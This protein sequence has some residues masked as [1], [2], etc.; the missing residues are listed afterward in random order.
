MITT[1]NWLC[2]WG[3]LLLLGACEQ[4]QPATAAP[5]PKSPPPLERAPPPAYLP[6]FQG[7]DPEEY[8]VA[9]AERKLG[10]YLLVP[11]TDP[12]LS[13]FTG[14]FYQP[15][16][17]SAWQKVAGFKLSC[18]GAEF[19]IDTV[20]IDQKGA[21]ELVVRSE[22][23]SYGSGGGTNCYTLSIFRCDNDVTKVLAVPVRYTD[24]V[25]VT[26]QGDPYEYRSIE[27][28]VRPQRGG[29]RVGRVKKEGIDCEQSDCE[30][31]GPR[32]KPG[33]YKLVGDTVIRE[34]APAR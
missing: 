5:P 27:Q 15:K 1:Q 33:T 25:F 9:K 6:G 11:F 26:F 30:N 17:A 23:S 13:T 4:R 8:V 7:I 3:F 16:P 14:V 31:C 20:N 12:E 32:L 28:A 29:I 10:R 18:Y 22:S 24:E 34:V 19:C 2:G 21:A